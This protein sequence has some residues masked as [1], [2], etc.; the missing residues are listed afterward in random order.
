MS[1]VMKARPCVRARAAAP[2]V[3]RGTGAP[4]SSVARAG[5][6]LSS[7]RRTSARLRL[8]ERRTTA[9]FLHIAPRPAGTALSHQLSSKHSPPTLPPSKLYFGSKEMGHA[10]DRPVRP[11]SETPSQMKDQPHSDRR[12]AFYS[13]YFR[14]AVDD[15][16]KVQHSTKFAPMRRSS[17]SDK[18]ES[19]DI[20]R[21]FIR[22][23]FS[24]RRSENDDGRNSPS[25]GKPEQAP[26]HSAVLQRSHDDSIGRFVIRRS[27]PA[28][29]SAV[30][31]S[32][33]A[34]RSCRSADIYG[35]RYSSPVTMQAARSTAVPSST[36]SLDYR[37]V[38]TE[39]VFPT[40]EKPDSD[41]SLLYAALSQNTVGLY[42]STEHV[43]VA[44][45]KML[46]GMG[47]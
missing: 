45:Y 43:F 8:L 23:R 29:G 28:S 9:R 21:T 10:S 40:A 27:P 35:S 1:R 38:K 13:K 42:W 34:S 36:A 31:E 22:R 14:K 7:L 30:P 47:C 46:Y 16:S 15:R 41:E 44:C 11:S 18:E 20:S 6:P 12:K 32:G 17:R 33:R 24:Q 2:T 39:Y 19:D 25:A 5:C 4:L 37:P 3:D 26:W